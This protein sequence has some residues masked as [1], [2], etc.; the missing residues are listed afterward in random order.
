[1]LIL[2]YVPAA[3]LTLQG[4]LEERRIRQEEAARA[5]AANRKRK[6]DKSADDRKAAI[7]MKRY[8][9]KGPQEPEDPLPRDASAQVGD[10]SR[11]APAEDAAPVVADDSASENECS[12]GEHLLP[13]QSDGGDDGNTDSETSVDNNLE[14]LDHTDHPLPPPPEER[15]C[16]ELPGEATNKKMTPEEMLAAALAKSSDGDAEATAASAEKHERDPGSR[17]KSGTEVVV[18]VPPYG[19]L[20]FYPIQ[21]NMTA[22]CRCK[23]HFDCKKNRTFNAA[24]SSASS[25]SKSVRDGQGRPVGLLVQWL[26]DQGNHSSRADHCAQHVMMTFSHASRKDARAWFKTLPGSDKI[27]S[28]ERAKRDDE[29]DSE[30]DFIY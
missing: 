23:K 26:R 19:S 22:Y 15:S 14:W 4:S 5:R 9:R 7:V 12:D 30:P 10:A 6:K 29:D 16:A 8:R 13:E 21:N 1:M 2:E 27:L 3:F 11:E 24:K 28:K 17:K 25:S 18:E 20:H